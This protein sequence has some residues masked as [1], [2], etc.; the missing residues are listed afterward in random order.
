MGPVSRVVSVVVGLALF[1]GLLLVA[2]EVVLAATGGG[3]W[4]IPWDEWH[5]WAARTSWEASGA[6]WLFVTLGVVGIVLLRVLFARRVPPALPLR[7]DGISSAVVS[8]R[9]LEQ[10]LVRWTH[11]LDGVAGARARIRSRRARV[12]VTTHRTATAGDLGP[13]VGRV[14]RDR[15]AG[16]GLTQVPRVAVDVNVR[17]GDG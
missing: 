11:G 5:S 6:R 7:S 14:A 1:A 3:P 12:V 8:R 4:V 10:W 17:D 16:L 15:L 13:R 9:S 2:T